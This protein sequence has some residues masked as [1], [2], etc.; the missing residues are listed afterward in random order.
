MEREGSH[1]VHNDPPLV[2]VPSQINPVHASP[3][4]FPKIHSNIILPSTPG[5]PSGLV[6]SGFPIKILY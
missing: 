1:R 2:P 5:L 6:R 4:Y 3:S